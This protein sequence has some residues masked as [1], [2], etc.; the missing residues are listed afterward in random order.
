MT[1]VE[2]TA[3]ASPAGATVRA[4]REMVAEVDPARVHP[5]AMVFPQVT[6][7]AYAALKADIAEH[8]LVEA[9]V[10]TTD[11][12]ILDGRARLRACRELGV[13][14]RFR[15]LV[16]DPWRYAIA[17]NLPRL[18]DMNARAIVAAT[19]ALGNPHEH[20]RP[21][22]RQAQELCDVSMGSMNRAKTVVRTGTTSLVDLTAAGQVALTT[23]ARVA[24]FPAAQQDRFC[25]RVRAGGDPK[26]IA[27]PGWRGDH[28]GPTPGSPASRREARY[29]HVQEPA[30]RAMADSFDALAVVV[31]A[32]DAGLDPAITP[33]QAAQWI[34]DL[35]RRARSY[36]Q[37]LTQ[38]KERSNEQHH[39]V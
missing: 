1:S 4:P 21:N 6:G 12:A 32:A 29:R 38:L 19:I 24:G 15:V 26:L 11:G 23:A 8:G 2:T 18:P 16:G 13:Q 36:R 31:S 7:A 33:E 9:V 30:L 14:P 5:A 34:R 10:V 28:E 17:C 3:V 20:R 35:S 39:D 22:A 27:R 37:L 25:D